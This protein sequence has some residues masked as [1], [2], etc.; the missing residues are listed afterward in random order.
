MTKLKILRITGFIEGLSLLILM[1]VAMPLKYLAGMPLAVKIV[2][3][4]HGVLFVVYVMMA[5]MVALDKGWT[6]KRLAT[7][8]IAAFLPFGTFIFDKSLMREEQNK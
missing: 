8:F 2:G 5:M 1:G 6:L 3:W 7:A 4:I